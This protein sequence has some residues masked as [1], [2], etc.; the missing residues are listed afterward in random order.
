MKKSAT[1][2]NKILMIDHIGTPLNCNSKNTVYL[3]ECN[4]R[5][6]HYTGSYKTK[7]RY[8]AN[9]YESTHCIFKNKRKVPKKALKNTFAQMTVHCRKNEVFY[10]G[11]L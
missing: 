10:K 7:F 2:R 5:G 8:G 3:I 9:N 11:F 1:Y 6:K 4:E